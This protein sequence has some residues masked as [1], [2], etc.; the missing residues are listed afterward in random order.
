M[1]MKKHL[2]FINRIKLY[3]EDDEKEINRCNEIIEK[4]VKYRDGILNE[5]NDYVTQ[6]NAAF[7]LIKQLTEPYQNVLLQ[8][9]F[10]DKSIECV[11]TEMKCSYDEIL[12][13]HNSA[14][15]Q[16]EKLLNG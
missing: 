10:Q 15:K 6:I 1:N 14:L 3:I 4:M 9:Y 5:H 2:K 16:L 7:T 8:V 12:K 11:A 13:I